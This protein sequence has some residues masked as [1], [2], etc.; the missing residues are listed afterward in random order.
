LNDTLLGLISTVSLSDSAPTNQAAAV[1]REIMARVDAEIDKLERLAATE[2]PR[3]GG[4]GG[5]WL[6]LPR[7]VAGVLARA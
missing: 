3:A 5:E 7:I 6:K 1:S 4:R 2:V